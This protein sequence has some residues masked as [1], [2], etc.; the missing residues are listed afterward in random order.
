M[1]HRRVLAPALLLLVLGSGVAACAPDVS[2]TAGRDDGLGI[3]WVDAAG[4]ARLDTT[5]GTDQVRTDLPGGEP[6]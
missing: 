5:R 4:G 2:P 1:P 3:L 6:T